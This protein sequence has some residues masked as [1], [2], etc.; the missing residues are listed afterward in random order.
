LAGGAP[1]A[2]SSPRGRDPRVRPYAGT[3]H[4][5]R[6]RGLPRAGNSPLGPKPVDR[7]DELAR[8]VR[9]AGGRDLLGDGR[10]PGLDPGAGRGMDA[11]PQSRDAEEHH[12]SRGLA[13]TLSPVPPLPKDRSEPRSPGVVL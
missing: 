9:E 1:T 13:R 7:G 8:P 12:R 5:S 3:G 11:D 6:A 10:G 4:D 2:R